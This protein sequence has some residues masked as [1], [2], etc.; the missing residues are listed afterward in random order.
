VAF[1]LYPGETVELTADVAAGPG[2]AD[3]KA[4][5]TWTA[6]D[7]G[8]IVSLKP[9]ANKCIVG[10]VSSGYVQV[11][12]KGKGTD[13]D[14]KACDISSAPFDVECITPTDVTVTITAGDVI[15]AEG[16]APRPAQPKTTFSEGFG[17]PNTAR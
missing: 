13:K 16:A 1:S 12:A 5:Q 4:A 10:Y 8:A 15:P 2:T 11:T 6:N 7:G 3:E 14:G 17:R 9:N